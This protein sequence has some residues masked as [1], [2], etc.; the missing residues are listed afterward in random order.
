MDAN[1][2]PHPVREGTVWW[3]GSSGKRFFIDPV[4]DMVTL[5]IAAA[6]PADGNGFPEDFTEAVYRV[7]VD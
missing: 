1:V 4:E 3:D 6:S 5:I 2:P 7:L